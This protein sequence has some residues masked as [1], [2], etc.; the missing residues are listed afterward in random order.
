WSSRQGRHD[1]ARDAD[2]LAQSYATDRLLLDQLLRQSVEQVTVLSE[3]GARL[4]SRVI[5]E[6]GD[7]LVDPLGGRLGVL[8]GRRDL[9]AEEWVSL[10]DVVRHGPNFLAHAPE[11]DHPP[12]QIGRCLEVALGAGR[13]L[14][15]HELF[16]RSA[17]ELDR[18]PRKQDVAP[19]V[20]AVLLGS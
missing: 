16:R 15:E 7:G 18:K 17:T 6:L 13:R 9:A 11:A 19:V 5:E 3:Q 1:A 2:Q 20:P 14:A 8:L 12:G 4:R 10:A